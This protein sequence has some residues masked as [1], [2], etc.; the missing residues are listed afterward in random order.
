[1]RREL[2]CLHI[3]A[4][5]SGATPKAFAGGDLTVLTFEGELLEA[6]GV[7]MRIEICPF[8]A[9]RLTHS[10]FEVLPPSQRS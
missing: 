10:I 7:A 1:M 2:K 9:G 8:C 3:L 6:Y 4:A 5:E